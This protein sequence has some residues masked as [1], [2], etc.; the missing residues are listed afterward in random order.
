MKLQK[1]LK[2][3]SDGIIETVRGRP[4]EF[5]SPM[6]SPVEP[7]GTLRFATDFATYFTIMFIRLSHYGTPY[8]ILITM[9]II[10]TYDCKKAYWQVLLAE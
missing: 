6:I 5:L 7:D 1:N 9:E 2:L 3:E 10:L 8:T 4:T